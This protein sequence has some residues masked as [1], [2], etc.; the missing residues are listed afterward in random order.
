M[1]CSRYLF[2]VIFLFIGN[3]QAGPVKPYTGDLDSPGF[4]FSDLHG[5]LHDI[6]DYKGKVLLL[7]FW[8]TWC[9]PCIK[10]LPSLQRLQDI[11]AGKE[12]AIVTIDIGEPAE[13]IE[14]Y[15]KEVNAD[16]LT[17]L[18]DREGISHKDW[19]IYVFPTNF[20]LDKR[21]KIRYAAVGALN[22]DDEE[23][24]IIINELLAED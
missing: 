14:P 16:N 6:K 1:K 3:A 9:P 11:Y 8:A 7:N 5:K 12:F 20:I 19:L 15:L 21:G 2:L 23:V 22:W 17:V 13:V 10:E 24:L 18:L 4:H